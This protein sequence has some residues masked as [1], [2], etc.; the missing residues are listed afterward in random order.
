MASKQPTIRE[1]LATPGLARPY[2]NVANVH[3]SE[4]SDDKQEPDALK[5]DIL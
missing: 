3:V 5:I 1:F 4:E 2:S